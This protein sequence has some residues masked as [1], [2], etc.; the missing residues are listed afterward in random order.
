MKTLI[1]TSIRAMESVVQGFN[2]AEYVE[3]TQKTSPPATEVI[4]LSKDHYETLKV[5]VKR[6]FFK[7]ISKLAVPVKCSALIGAM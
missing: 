1:D 7:V 2:H 6:K 3:Y 4:P 5:P